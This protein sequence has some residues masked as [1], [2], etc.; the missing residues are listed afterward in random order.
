NIKPLYDNEPW[1]GHRPTSDYLIP[2]G[3]VGYLRRPKPEHKLAPRGV[4]YIMLSIDTNYSRRTFH[5]RD[6]TTGQVTMRQVILWHSTADAGEAVS[7]NTANKG[8]GG[9]DTGIT[10]RDPRKPPTTRLHW[11]AWRPSRMSRNRNS[12]S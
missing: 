9:R 6:L 1:V 12:M 7:R 4:K 10:R 11:G 3:T 2:F 8:G 5:V